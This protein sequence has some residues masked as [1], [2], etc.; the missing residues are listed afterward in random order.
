MTYSKSRGL[1]ALI[2]ISLPLIAVLAVFGCGRGEPDVEEFPL[3]VSF[4]VNFFPVQKAL[5]IEDAEG[6]YV[7]TLHASEWLTGYGEEFQVLTDWVDASKEARG[8]KTGEQIDA[9]TEATLRASR[10]K[11]RYGWDLIDWKGEKIPE[12]DYR[13]ILQCD[14]AEG[15]VIT[16]EAGINTGKD[17]VTAELNPDPPEHPQGLEMYVEEAV[18][19]Y[20]PL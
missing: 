13:I 14:G 10:E 5:W 11:V 8:R 6:N 4:R 12:G 17:A 15:V 3:A 18:V 1:P 16:W 19:G 2:K 9:F 20:N 7:K